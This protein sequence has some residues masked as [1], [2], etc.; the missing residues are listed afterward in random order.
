VQINTT[1]ARHN[2]DQV[3]ALADL[4]AGLD[5]VLWSIFFLVPTGRAIASQR[6]APEQ[7]EQVFARLFAQSRRKPYAIKTTEAPHYRRFVL[8]A[9]KTDAAPSRPQIGS[10]GTNDGRGVMFIS[11]TGELFPSGFLPVSCG[12]FPLDSVVKVYQESAMFRALRQSER[13][14]GKCGVCEFREVCGGS[15]ARA[16]ALTGDPL[17]SDPDCAYIPVRWNENPQYRASEV[18]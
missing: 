18:Y 14:S 15:R 11:H 8:Q 2:V 12:K 5:I 4:L 13:I 6:I 9:Q 7:Y 3:D 1:I 16:F 17:A 10:I